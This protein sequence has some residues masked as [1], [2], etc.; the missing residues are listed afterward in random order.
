MSAQK[1][2]DPGKGRYESMTPLFRQNVLPPVHKK[3]AGNKR[4]P[5]A[6]CVALLL[7]FCVA[8]AGCMSDT[9]AGASPAPGP[10]HPAPK[11][12][13]GDIVAAPSSGA[14]S[15]FLVLRY[16]PATDEY[17]RAPIEKNPDGTYGY[18]STNLTARSP[19]TVMEKVYTVKA[20]HVAV[21]SVP[22]RESAPEILAATEE[23]PNE[24]P[25]INGI[26]PDFASRDTAVTLTVTGSNFRDG[27]TV[28]LVKPGY[29]PVT[30]VSVTL[31]GSS[32][33]CVFSLNGQSDGSYMLVVTNPD[34]QSDV[35]Q[36]IFT[37]GE[38]PPILTS[39]YPLS[40][41]LGRMIPIS[42]YGQNFRNDVK[43]SFTKEKGEL[44][45]MNPI[46][47]DSIRI[48]CDL[49]LA[50][51]GA[52]AGEWTVTVLNIDDRKKGTWPKKFIVTNATGADS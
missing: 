38:A 24:A 42:V 6:T 19:R 16:D 50:A 47:K 2:G 31:T 11:Y 13:E 8:T 7:I 28:K 15:P 22:I 35:R 4:T 30:A 40:G 23:G 48:T 9:S 12:R 51:A 45:C 21:A 37:I 20:G 43:V 26:S 5:T 49:D 46:T 3:P 1:A 17:I 27:A 18:R 32:L 34:G 36:G 33:T 39:V 14:S 10:L 25:A 52:S 29:P 44:V 41:G